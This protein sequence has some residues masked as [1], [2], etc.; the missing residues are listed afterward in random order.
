MNSRLELFAALLEYPDQS[1]LERCQQSGIREFAAAI[2]GLS[3]AELQEQ[4][5]ATFDWNPPTALEIGWHLYG[6]Q[7]ARGEFLV[8]VR[9]E[10]R[11]HGISES[12]ELPDHLTHILRLLARMNE[13][14]ATVY[15]QKYVAPAVAKICS[16]LDQQRTPFALLMRAVREELPAQAEIPPPRV[17]LPVL[18]GGD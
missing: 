16:A 13:D 9:Q 1:Y 2:A 15:A 14:E 6:E 5:I 12:R 8:E 18:A 17:E 7:Y 4:F 3:L 11:R 10:L